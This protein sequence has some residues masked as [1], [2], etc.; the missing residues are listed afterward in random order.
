MYKHDAVLDFWHRV[1]KGIPVP[2]MAGSIRENQ[3]L[4]AEG[5]YVMQHFRRHRYPDR[6]NQV[7][8]D[9]EKLFR[10][11]RLI[12][13]SNDRNASFTR[14]KLHE[15]ISNHIDFS[16]VD[17][18]ALQEK[19]GFRYEFLNHEN[20]NN[21]PYAPDNSR[22]LDVPDLVHVDLKKADLM[23]ECLRSDR[24]IP[25]LTR[26]TMGRKLRACMPH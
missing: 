21:R 14:L 18:A 2:H 26:W 4:S 19:L 17:N 22:P 1:L 16:A 3:S 15:H 7:F 20:P 8:R 5:L 11:I 10:L 12:E 6:D 24:R 9:Y 25:M 23:V 13:R